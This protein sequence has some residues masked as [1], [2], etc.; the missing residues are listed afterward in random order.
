MSAT[1][2]CS[3][4]K[5]HQMPVSFIAIEYLVHRRP[6]MLPPNQQLVESL[7]AVTCHK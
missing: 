3:K 6:N 4:T 7:D 5:S 1:R 2:Y